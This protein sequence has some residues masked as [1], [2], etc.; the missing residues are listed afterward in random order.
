MKIF[1]LETDIQKIKERYCHGRDGECEVLFTRYH[2]L[3]F[4]FAIL[5]EIIITIILFTIGIM[6]AVWG[7][8][9]DWT[10]GILVIV[11]VI[12]VFFNVLKAYIDWMYDFI[13]VTTDKVV[14]VDQTSFFRREVKPIHIENI[15]GVSMHTQFGGI[16]PFGAIHI[17]LKEGEGGGDIEKYYVPNAENVSSKIS[18]IVTA[19]QRHDPP[20]GYRERVQQEQ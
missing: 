7:W 15:G 12:F 2:G 17:H 9:M 20:Q 16:F 18:A 11:W 3:S 5:R 10:I 4:L 13:F 14:L 1:A 6:G 8:S 19:Y